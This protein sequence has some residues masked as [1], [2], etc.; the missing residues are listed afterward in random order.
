VECKL[1]GVNSRRVLDPRKA[2]QLAFRVTEISDDL[3]RSSMGV[4]VIRFGTPRSAGEN[5]GSTWEGQRQARECRRQA[6]E[7]R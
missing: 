6:L 5:I 2:F 3:Y 7:C 4:I 1:R